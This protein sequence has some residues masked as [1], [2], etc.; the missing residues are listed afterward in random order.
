MSKVI[1][2]LLFLTLYSCIRE[3]FKQTE[4]IIGYNY[5]Q[6][7]TP[8]KIWLNIFNP[9][10]KYL[11]SMILL[12]GQ[13]EHSITLPNAPG[14]II[15]GMSFTDSADGRKVFVP[16]KYFKQEISLQE[17]GTNILSIDLAKENIK[18]LADENYIDEDGNPL[19]VVINPCTENY[20]NDCKSG[21][22]FG[23]SGI[24]SVR[25]KMFLHF[26]NL[27]SNSPFNPKQMFWMSQCIAAGTSPSS[28][29]L[30]VKFPYLTE[31]KVPWNMR[32]EIFYDNECNISYQ[33]S[34]N[35][36]QNSFFGVPHSEESEDG[37][38]LK[39]ID[40]GEGKLA[41]LTFIIDKVKSNEL[42]VLDINCKSEVCVKNP[43][44]ASGLCAAE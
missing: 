12:P 25:L 37:P 33:T 7:T 41:S 35:K 6:Q 3:D 4:L 9:D 43:N 15:Y 8:S 34:Q 39:I 29:D 14:Y 38:W 24:G 1:I 32:L 5:E 18:L 2:S 20:Y 30:F 31:G 44:E 22:D 10:L 36:L 42:C 21:T 11:Y 27:E 26:S 19:K 17:G 13:K 28:F 16:E 23:H 40:G